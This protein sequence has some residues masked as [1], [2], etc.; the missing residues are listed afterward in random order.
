[1]LVNI[2]ALEE[3]PARPSSLIDKICAVMS[4][5]DNKNSWVCKWQIINMLTKGISPISVSGKLPGS[6]DEV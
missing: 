2:Q 1:M 6:R 3:N 4:P 5:E